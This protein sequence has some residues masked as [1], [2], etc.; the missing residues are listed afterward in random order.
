MGRC[1]KGRWSG[2]R[3]TEVVLR[4]LRGETLDAV[5]RGLGVSPDRLAEWR[6]EAIVA[7]Q[8]GLQSR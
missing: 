1:D 6:D 3:K 4:I 5:S 7:M 8:P 2:R